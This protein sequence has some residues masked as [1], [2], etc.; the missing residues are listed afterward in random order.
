MLLTCLRSSSFA[1]VCAF[2]CFAAAWD[3]VAFLRHGVYQ[4]G[5]FKF[6]IGIPKAY[7]NIAPK[8]TFLSR[9][10]HPLV[11]EETGELCIKVSRKTN[12]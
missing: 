10:F 9:V 11:D 3:G 2:A 12:K 4:G 5:L 1:Y 6:R 8:L 7:P